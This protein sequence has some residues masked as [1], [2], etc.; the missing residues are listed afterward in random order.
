MPAYNAGKYIHEA[1]CS[2]LQQSFK[3]FELLVIN[4]GSTDNTLELALSFNDPRI[5]VI[6]KEHEGIA[7]ALNTGLKLASADY[8]ARFDADDI[9]RPNRLQTQLD[10]F[11]DHPD[12]VLIGS[13]ADYILENGEFL[14]NFKCIA[15]SNDEVK[16]NLYV[17]CPFIHSSVMYRREDVLKAGGY[18]VHAHNFEDYLLW[19][20]LAKMGKMQNLRESLIKVRLNAASATIDEKW[21]GER[22]RQLKRQATTRG[23]ITAQE[24][25]E[26]LEIIRKQDVRKIKEGAYHALCGKK[27]L[28]NNYQPEKARSHVRKAISIKPL[29]LDNYLLYA[30]SYFPAPVIAWLHKQSP[31][32]L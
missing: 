5:V 29:R 15:H 26:L 20:N 17:Y 4:D 31:N 11:H 22:F 10:F 1:I 19:T 13:D 14:F 9:C 27:F 12:Y 28:A 25:N 30:A 23:S 6:N 3:N 7:T 18:D 8:I 24:G 2:V 32:R 16:S 21:R